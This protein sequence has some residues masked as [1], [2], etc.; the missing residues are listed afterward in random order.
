MTYFRIVGVS[1]GE[2]VHATWQH[3]VLT[4]SYRLEEV[5]LLAAAV[6]NALVEVGGVY[7]DWP[8]CDPMSAAVHLAGVLDR[9]VMLEYRRKCDAVGLRRVW[10]VDGK[11]MAES[12]L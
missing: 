9:M 11:P 10:Y 4:M 5:A 12:V 8:E 3:E 6:E 2:L 7:C 1:M